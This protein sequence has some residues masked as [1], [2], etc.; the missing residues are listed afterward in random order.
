MLRGR[1]RGTTSFMRPF[2]LAYIL[3]IYIDHDIEYSPLPT[4]LGL[5]VAIDRAVMLPHEFRDLNQT[6]STNPTEEGDTPSTQNRGDVAFNKDTSNHSSYPFP[7]PTDAI[8]PHDTSAIDG[9]AG[10]ASNEAHN[11]GSNPEPWKQPQNQTLLSPV[12]EA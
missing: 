2:F 8:G 5:P 7:G 1:H 4:G 10:A 6:S 11:H 12:A 9:G 3:E